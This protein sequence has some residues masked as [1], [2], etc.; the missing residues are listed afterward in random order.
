[1]LSCHGVGAV[2]WILFFTARAYKHCS[3]EAGETKAD[4]KRLRLILVAAADLPGARSF[5]PSLQ[6]L[7]NFFP[8]SCLVVHAT[9]S[10]IASEKDKN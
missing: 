1:M 2:H 4:L 8:R 5:I 6:R 9:W 10:V 3:V 7:I